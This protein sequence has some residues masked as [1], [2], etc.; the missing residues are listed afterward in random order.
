[1]NKRIVIPTLLLL[2]A[3]LLSGCG[4]QVVSGSGKLNTENRTVSGFTSV[5]L[6]GIGNLYLTQGATEAVRIETEDNLIPY[7]ETVVE[8]STLKIDI[9]SQY[10]GVNLQPTQPIKFYVTLPKLEA[11]TLAGS[12]NIFGGT[13]KTGAF[14]ISLLGSGNISADTLSATTVDINL[15]GSGNISL[16]SISAT[17]VTNSIAGSGNI[18]VD[19]LA[20]DTV[21]SKTSGSG[22]ITFSGKVSGQSAEILGSGDYRAGGLKCATTT[23]RVTGSGNSQVASSSTLDV[24]ILGSGDVTYSGTPKLN[25]SISGSGKVNPAN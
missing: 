10:L 4:F 17:Q 18:Q 2:A 1:M 11:V 8:G 5:S 16:G 20:A 6:A 25:V 15:S 23:L 3:L 24:S 21:S 7:F 22:N 19:A 12:G 13:L 9:K 14:K